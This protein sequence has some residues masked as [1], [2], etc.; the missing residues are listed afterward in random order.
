MTALLVVI[1]TVAVATYNLSGGVLAMA[2]VSTLLR[3]PA[4][5]ALYGNLTSLDTAGAYVL[6]KV[7]IVVT[8]AV[9][10]WA[11]LGA[12]RISRGAEDTG[13]WD[14][15]VTEP[16]GRA[17]V[18]R[19][20]VGVLALSG[21]VVGAA[22]TVALVANGQR[23]LDSTL[24]GVGLVGLAWCAQAAGLVASQLLAPRR[25]AS[26]MALGVVGVAYLARMVADASTSGSWIRSLT[27]FGW[28]EDVGAFQ[29]HR[30]I[31][32]APLLVAP[33]IAIAIIGALADRRD[34]GSAWWRR[35]DRG[36]LRAV[37]LRSPWR[38]AWRELASTLLVWL[39]VTAAVGLVIGYLTNALVV[40][41]RSDRSFT[42]LLDRWHLGQLVSVRGYVGE[43]GTFLALGLSFFVVAV[44]ATVGADATAGRLEI[45]F[46]NGAGRRTWLAAVGVVAIGGAVL[47]AVITAVGIWGG[48]GASGSSLSLATALGATFN[49]L[50]V[51]PVVLGAT[52]LVVVLAPRVVQVFMAGLLGLS[53]LDAALGPPLHWPVAVV[54]LSIYHYLRLVPAA[55]PDWWSGAGFVAL[56]GAALGIAIQLFGRTDLVG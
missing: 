11:A 8:L 56:G 39:T 7:G 4:F 19:Q 14:L 12:T 20:T 13:T 35:R 5:R 40:F 2:G 26:Q 31:W 37:L 27:P 30:A 29:H 6:W 3:N 55:P 51:V 41:G 53:Y 45:P 17:R 42:R 10:I 24:Y 46:G 15:L 1:V 21:L 28:L 47:I 36:P 43:I 49:A 22:V 23:L 18:F 38:F 44:V 52:A 34:V 50:S 32:L 33:A 16:V 48:V 25:S 9:S 54:D